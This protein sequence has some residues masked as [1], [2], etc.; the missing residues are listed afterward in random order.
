MG[1]LMSNLRS[2]GRGAAQL[3]D[4]VK[5]VVL[6]LKSLYE[7]TNAISAETE[8]QKVLELVV[9]HTI[10]ATKAERGFVMLLND[11]ELVPVMARNA[12]GRLSDQERR[13]FSTTLAG[14]AVD[15]GRTFVSKDTSAD[16]EMATKSVV[17]YNIRSCICSPLQVKGKSIGCL[18]V[19]AKDSI[20]SFVERDID[21][22]QALTGQA[23]IAIENARL[24]GRVTRSNRT[25]KRKLSELEAM[26]AVSQSLSFGQEQEEVLR[27]ILDQSIRVIGSK[28]GSIML[29]DPVSDVLEVSVCRG[30]LDPSTNQ[31]IKLRSGE[32]IAG[33]V[34]E[35]GEGYIGKEGANDP[36]FARKSDREGDIHQIICV[37]LKGAEG[38]IGVLSLVNRNEGEFTRD[39]LQLLS[40]LA[41][42][43]AVS[44]E[45]ARLYNL[46]VF[47]GLTKIHVV[48]YLKAWLAKEIST[49]LRHDTELSFLLLDVDHFKKFNDTYG[50]QVG[51]QVLVELAQIMK[52]QARDSDLCAR[53]G[54][55][56]F[57]VGLPQTD[58]A[59]AEM[60]AER[61]RA[62]VE[63]HRV[64]TSNQKLQVTISIGICN[65][66]ISGVRTIDEMIK[67]ADGCLYQAKAR[68]RNCWVSHKPSLSSRELAEQ[69]T[70][71]ITGIMKAVG[72][73]EE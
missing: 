33:W 28:R 69:V 25:L 68:G 2:D 16:P 52:E 55:E 14:K 13:E 21:F 23:A 34:L 43:A 73:A 64:C 35:C 7:I 39:D 24:L 15:S 29:L 18:Y 70:A 53:Y 65:L 54:G 63:A 36:N 72:P 51:D 41:H 67:A 40:N 22:F 12:K 66:K 60:L 5:R 19:D 37:P 42:H 46:A 47:D 4:Q 17:D 30:E 32:G 20:R 62:R 8:L 57:C 9:V 50:H 26:F 11:G 61:L 58:L 31:R 38:S 27:T 56:E 3:Q 49:S 6:E 59:G 10:R 1:S 71:R 45:K 48:R 44:I